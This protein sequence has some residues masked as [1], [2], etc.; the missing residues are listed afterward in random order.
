[1]CFLIVT[2]LF[3]SVWFLF[4]LSNSFFYCSNC[5]QLFFFVLS[6][7]S[8]FK[9]IARNAL[10][11]SCLSPIQLVLLGFFFLVPSFETYSYVTLF[12]LIFFHFYVFSKLFTFPYLREMALC[13][14][15]AMGLNS[16][17]PSC[18]QS[19]MLLEWPLYG[20]CGSFCYD[21]L[22]AIETCKHGCLL[23]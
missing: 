23:T 22:T 6:S 14:R 15:H 21:K 12:C 8:I 17:L 3:I 20:L 19:Y 1:M 16:I 10:L 18:H 2:A 9:I 5:V 11:G 7:L 4:I 13:R